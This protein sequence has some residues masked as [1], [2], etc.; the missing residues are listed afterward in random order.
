MYHVDAGSASRD[1]RGCIPSGR[2]LGVYSSSM[3][4]V[5]IVQSRSSIRHLRPPRACLFLLLGPM[6]FECSCSGCRF[7]RDLRFCLF[8]PL[9]FPPRFASR[10]STFFLTIRSFISSSS[11]ANT[12]DIR[13]FQVYSP[14]GSYLSMLSGR[15][16]RGRRKVMKKP[17]RAIDMRRTATVLDFAAGEFSRASHVNWDWDVRPHLSS[18]FCV[19]WIDDATPENGTLVVVVGWTSGR[20]GCLRARPLWEWLWQ[21]RSFVYLLLSTSNMPRIYLDLQIQLLE[22]PGWPSRPEKI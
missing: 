2:I 8:A 15:W 14:T 10:K 1:D 3:L 7:S 20:R 5:H 19:M 9:Y 13:N 11:N 16:V 18:P 4:V 17:V 22:N 6:R 21:H 12:T